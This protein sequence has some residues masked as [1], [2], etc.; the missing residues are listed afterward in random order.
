MDEDRIEI[1]TPMSPEKRR[2]LEVKSRFLTG[3]AVLS[4]FVYCAVISAVALKPSSFAG[5]PRA[6]ADASKMASR[7]LA[8]D[9]TNSR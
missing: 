6:R 7:V 8:I 5:D 3:F 2:V 4:I 9:W 1:I